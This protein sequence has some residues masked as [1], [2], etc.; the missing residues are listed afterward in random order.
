VQV[1]AGANR[2]R[3]R[4]MLVFFHAWLLH[5]LTVTRVTSTK[6]RGKGLCGADT[7]VRRF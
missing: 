6:K 1:R 5:W 2:F 7:L 3:F 4:M